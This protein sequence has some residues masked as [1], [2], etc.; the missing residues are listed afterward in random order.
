MKADALFNSMPKIGGKL[1]FC[2]CSCLS[3][4]S[5]ADEL[6]DDGL[7]MRLGMIMIAKMAESLATKIFGVS[8]NSSRR[9]L[10]RKSTPT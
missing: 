9:K 2:V 7:C 3:F 8:T 10:S 1:F 4:A 6:R 5:W